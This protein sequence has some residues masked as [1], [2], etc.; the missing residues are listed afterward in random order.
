MTKDTKSTMKAKDV[1]KEINKTTRIVMCREINKTSKMLINKKISKNN[2]ISINLNKIV[3]LLIITMIN[4]QTNKIII[5]KK[6]N[7]QII[8]MQEILIINKIINHIVKG[9]DHLHSIRTNKTITIIEMLTVNKMVINKTITNSVHIHN[10]QGDVVLV[11]EDSKIIEEGHRNHII[12]EIAE[13][14]IMVNIIITSS[15]NSH[16]IVMEDH[17]KEVDTIKEDTITK[18]ANKEV[19]IPIPEEEEDTIN[20]CHHLLRHHKVLKVIIDPNR[21][22]ILRMKGIGKFS[23]AVYQKK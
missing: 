9:L 2:R 17:H 19:G 13:K 7:K 10:S 22:L 16:H 5:S 23:L 11:I 15:I 4:K 21:I 3:P 20:L 8:W 18:E 1:L 14:E 12:V 6:M